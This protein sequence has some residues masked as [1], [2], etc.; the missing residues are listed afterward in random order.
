MKSMAKKYANSTLILSICVLSVL[1]S[2][3]VADDAPVA[4]SDPE[5]Q[6]GREVYVN[7]CSSCHGSQGEG[8]NGTKLNE[9]ALLKVYPEV[10]DQKLVIEQG[11]NAMPA[12]SEKLDDTEIDAVVRYTREVLNNE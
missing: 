3:C 6:T 8:R 11:R 7:S 9:G 10:A 5:L 4:G 1:V 2:G 12:F